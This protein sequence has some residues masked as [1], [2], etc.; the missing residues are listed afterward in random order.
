M[1]VRCHRAWPH[2]KRARD[3]KEIYQPIRAIFSAQIFPFQ[4]GTTPTMTPQPGNTVKVTWPDGSIVIG[5]FIGEARGYYVVE[6]SGKDLACNKHA[7][8]IEVI[9]DE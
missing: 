8:K 1:K 6:E 3:R 2:L 7:V 4:T 5:R 9:D